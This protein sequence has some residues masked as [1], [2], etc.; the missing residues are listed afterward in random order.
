M[1]Y[2]IQERKGF[3]LITGEVGTGKT[4]LIRYLVGNLDRQKNGAV[5]TALIF[6]PKLTAANFIQYIL[7]D[8][9]ATVRGNSKGDYLRDLNEFLL[10]AYEK[11]E[12]VVLIVDEA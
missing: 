8:L 3:L 1:V 9:G 4:I 11:G 12:K 6:N 7:R 5:K 10:G 2:G